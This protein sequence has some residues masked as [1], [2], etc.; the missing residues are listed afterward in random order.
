MVAGGGA[1][2]PMRTRAAGVPNPVLQVA[3]DRGSYTTEV[4]GPGAHNFNSGG[5]TSSC[6]LDGISEHTSEHCTN[7]AAVYSPAPCGSSG[8][9]V[10]SPSRD[11]PNSAGASS[12]SHGLPTGA[13]ASSLS[14]GTPTGVSDASGVTNGTFLD[15]SEVL[16][17]TTTRAWI[18]KVDD[19]LRPMIPLEE[20]ALAA[21]MI[22]GIVLSTPPGFLV[23]THPRGTRVV[24]LDFFEAYLERKVIAF[25]LPFLRMSKYIAEKTLPFQLLERSE[26]ETEPDVLRR[27]LVKGA[28]RTSYDADTRQLT[29]ILPDQAAATSWHARSILFRAKR[30]QLLRPTILERE[31]IT[32]SSVPA[33]AAGRNILHY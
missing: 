25:V 27:E 5:N 15:H 23:C 10:C 26:G 11:A 32:I 7:R 29:S 13:V 31:D 12:P 9:V 1:G 4:T 24:M 3:A 28:K 18:E 17:R 30:L 21:W 20:E 6:T 8:D 14:R 19:D 22:G 16:V 33:T 2:A